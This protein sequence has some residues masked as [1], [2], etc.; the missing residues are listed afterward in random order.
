MYQFKN[1]S[2]KVFS[3]ATFPSGV[4]VSCCVVVIVISL[5]NL[6][7]SL[8]SSTDESN[9]LSKCN[10]HDAFNIITSTIRRT[11]KLRIRGFGLIVVF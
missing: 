10:H 4:S 9:E 6:L 7:N 5:S 8:V 11:A 1:N 2:Q 3:E